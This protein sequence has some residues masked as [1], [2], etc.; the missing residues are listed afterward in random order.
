MPPRK[1]K[2]KPIKK[3]SPEDSKDVSSIIERFRKSP[4]RTETSDE[5]S[6]NEIPDLDDEIVEASAPSNHSNLLKFLSKKNDKVVK[7]LIEGKSIIQ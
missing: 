4:R 1:I 3:P 5:D 7:E 2:K 6:E